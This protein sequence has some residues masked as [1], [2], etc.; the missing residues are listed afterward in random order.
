MFG[1]SIMKQESFSAA[2][3]MDSA[4]I[5]LLEDLQRK[6]TYIFHRMDLLS[7]ALTHRSWVNEHPRPDQE[8]NERLEFLGDA[9]LD[10][11]ASDLLI[12]HFPDFDEGTLSKMRARLVNEKPLA[13]WALRLGL[14]EALLLGRGEESSGGRAKESLLANALEAVIAAVYLD[15]GFD[16]ARK[17]V[18]AHLKPLL[19]D[20]TLKSECFD[21]KTELQEYCQKIFKTAPTYTLLGESGP[22]HDRTFI[23]E[24]AIDG[25]FHQTGTGKSKK[26]AQKNAASKALELLRYENKN[27]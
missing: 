22:D 11:C 17:F 4:R 25:V 14:G 15:A 19:V 9:V 1:Y 8:D 24:V 23:I 7:T 18:V 6:L 21:Y 3:A 5:A 26:D 12:E 27:P 2:E 10:L 13:A 20:D 16:Q